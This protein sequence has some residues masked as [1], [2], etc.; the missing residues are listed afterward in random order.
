MRMVK[1][2][3]VPLLVLL[4]W[5]VGSRTG[6]LAEGTFSRP[7]DILA[8]V[9][10]IV[11]DGSLALATFQTLQAAFVG[12]LIAILLGIPLGMLIGLS[13]FAKRTVSPTLDVVRP[14]PPVALIPLSLLIFGFGVSMEAVVV[15]F[16]CIWSIAIATTAAVKAIEGRLLEVARSL[17]MSAASYVRKIVMPA[18][19]ARIA[20]GI[21]LAI[22]IALVVAVTV[23]IVVNPRGLGYGII[24]A[25]QSLRPDLMYA[26]LLWVGFIGWFINASLSALDR[27]F[28]WRFGTVR[29]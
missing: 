29:R 11:F 3:V 7:S 20:V 27:R 23:E 28:F 6:I 19:F 17:E 10:A 26:Q 5:E 14:I 21:R 13:S 15:A 22:G 4:I 18:A 2:V 16:A 25:Q 24:M 1:G 8:A 9:G 12:L